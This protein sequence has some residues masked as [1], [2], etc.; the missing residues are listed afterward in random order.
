MGTANAGIVAAHRSLREFSHP[1]QARP[2]PWLPFV[3]GKGEIP[4]TGSL[5]SI[6]NPAVVLSALKH[7]DTDN[8][9]VVRVYSTS[10]KPEQ[11]LLKVPESKTLACI[12][13]LRECWN[14][15][16]S[17]T[18]NGGSISLEIPPHRIMTLLIR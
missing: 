11:C 2:M 9:W 14:D 18:V 15:S 1:L 5:L 3:S 7:H 13:D 12:T 10:A 8:C 17:F 6:N 4:A 16:E